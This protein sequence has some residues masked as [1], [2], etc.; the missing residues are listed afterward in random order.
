M[1]IVMKILLILIL[2]H[3]ILS[4][5]SRLAHIHTIRFQYKFQFGQINL[6]FKSWFV[7]LKISSWFFSSSGTCVAIDYGL[8]NLLFKKLHSLVQLAKIPADISFFTKCTMH[9]ADTLSLGFFSHSLNYLLPEHAGI[10]QSL[11]VQG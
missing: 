8:I 3:I 1:V 5:G 4:T 10:K 2:I 6:I 9:N 11:V 7:Q